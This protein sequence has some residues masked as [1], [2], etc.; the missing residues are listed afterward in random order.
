MERHEL[1]ELHY[2]T[3]IANLPSIMRVGIVSHHR[4]AKLGGQSIAMAEVQ[5]RRAKKQ[6][7]Q[8]LPLH[9]Y[10][11]LYINARN[12]MLYKRISERYSICVLRVSP[13]VLDIK[14]VV[15]S[16]GN[17][18]SK[19]S[20]FGTPVT[21]LL[22]I[23]HEEVFAHS[24]KHDDQRD[25]WRHKVRMCAEVLVPNRVDPSF[26]IGAYVC[27]PTPKREVE[28]VSTLVATINCHMFF[29]YA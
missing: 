1:S 8:G 10:V 15:V 21:G 20:R 7:P 28:R 26:I 4:A 9:E 13:E 14:G 6:V 2:I 17:A 19:Y 23:S 3:P 24:W 27:G 5:Q 12:P 11:N 25:E 16:D 18:A 29:G 22:N